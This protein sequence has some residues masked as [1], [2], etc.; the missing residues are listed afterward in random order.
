M[1]VTHVPGTAKA[2]Q[3]CTGV[4]QT[5]TPPASRSVARFCSYRVYAQC[6][7]TVYT[8]T[9]ACVLHVPSHAMCKMNGNSSRELRNCLLF[10]L[11]CSVIDRKK[12]VQNGSLC[13]CLTWGKRQ[14]VIPSCPAV[15]QDSHPA[16]YIAPLYDLRNRSVRSDVDWLC[17]HVHVLAC[18]GLAELRS[19]AEQSCRR[20]LSRAAAP[21]C[22]RAIDRCHKCSSQVSRFV[23]TCQ[24]AQSLCT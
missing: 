19:R 10:E 21:E 11:A 14:R 8:H 5:K 7:S 15:T 24:H 3:P 2:K 20:Q 6:H 1:D 9:P 23:L 16:G 4:P 13:P 12:W 22:W 18:T 17:V